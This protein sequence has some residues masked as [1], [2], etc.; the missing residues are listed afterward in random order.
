MMIGTDPEW[1]VQ[2]KSSV[3]AICGK[4]GGTKNEPLTFGDSENPGFK[5]HE[6]NVCIELAVPPEPDEYTATETLYHGLKLLDSKLKENGLR[7]AT[8]D[9]RLFPASQLTHKNAKTFGCDPDYDA[10]TGGFDTR[11]GI[12]LAA[13]GGWRFAGGHIHL[14]GQ[15]NCPPFVVALLADLCIGTRYVASEPMTER[16][17]YYGQPGIFRPKPYG[18]EYRT[19]GNRW[20]RNQDTVFDTYTRA[21]SLGQWLEATPASRIKRLTDSINWTV[22]REYMMNGSAD[23]SAAI[24]EPERKKARQ[25]GL[26]V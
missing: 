23:T 25:A 11:A 20:T 14:G 5:Y 17:K 24:L 8:G 15:F 22:V 1:F 19:L 18:V 26:L 3:V 12:D 13:L 10:Y 9:A 2:E 16:R 21:R 4:I 6:D 7:R